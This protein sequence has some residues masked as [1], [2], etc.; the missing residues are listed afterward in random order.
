[1]SDR[2]VVLGLAPAR[3]RWFTAVA[4]W[5]NAGTVPVEF[6]KC[7][8]VEEVRS[9]LVS[10]RPFSAAL[11]DTAVPGVDRDLVE[12]AHRSGCPLVA[13][14]PQGAT[15]LDPAAVLDPDPSPADLLEILG[16]VAAP[17]GSA[18]IL[19]GDEIDQPAP[20]WRGTVIAVC[21][22]GG[23]GVSTVAAAAAQ[24]LAA[25]PRNGGSVLL[26]D[27]ARRAEQAMLHEARDIV[28]GV[29]ELVE[30]HR[31]GSPSIDEIRSLAFSDPR[32]GY[33]LLLGLRRARAWS[34]I[35]PRAFE[36]AFDGLRR[37]HRFVVCDCDADVEGEREGGSVDVEERNVMARTAIAAAGVC[38]V[39]AQPGMKGIHSLARTLSDLVV[40]GVA[41]ARL[42]PVVN[43]APRSPRARAEIVSALHSLLPRQAPGLAS[44]VFLP[45][46]RVDDAFRTGAPLPSS[47]VDPV[48]RAAL[49][50]IERTGEP[51]GPALE[52]VRPGTLG[53]ADD[54][55]SAAG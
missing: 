53:L 44:P 11:V 41:G 23:T 32:R 52:A 20:G 47:I 2:Y 30:A 22:P 31:A 40:F 48:T 39:V 27:L 42:V 33:R 6:V 4:Q 21:G 45:D 15:L 14:G 5:A 43:R 7:V 34:A 12:L 17:V 49:A 16:S 55:G 35:R 19:P 18:D 54:L 9:R 28:P 10:G 8:S 25:D 37:S 3:A 50:V 24:G 1:M 26:A 38:L 36:S 13:V 51:V 46:R 29:Q